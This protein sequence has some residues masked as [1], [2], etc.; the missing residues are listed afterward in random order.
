VNPIGCGKNITV[1]FSI[2]YVWTHTNIHNY[3][4]IGTHQYNHTQTWYT[5]ANTHSCCTCIFP[6]PSWRCYYSARKFLPVWYLYIYI[7]TNPF[8]IKFSTT[9][10]FFL[11]FNKK[12]KS[13]TIKINTYTGWLTMFLV[14]SFHY[15][16]N[17]GNHRVHYILSLEYL[18]AALRITLVHYWYLLTIVTCKYLNNLFI[19]IHV[20]TSVRTYYNI[21]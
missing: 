4:N 3:A 14:L 9:R 19:S 6:L 20:C 21:I 2:V 13:N 16:R 18:P 12:K 15:Y 7:Y 1:S 8:R 5:F 17:T 10:V 11:S